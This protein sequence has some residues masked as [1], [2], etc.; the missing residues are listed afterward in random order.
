MNFI[1]L[2]YQRENK[3]I[4]TLG[5]KLLFYYLP[6]VAGSRIIPQGINYF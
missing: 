1:L 4:D 2:R 3:S 5:G 6:D